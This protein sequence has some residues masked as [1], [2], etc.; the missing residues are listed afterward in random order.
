MI[1]LLTAI[2]WVSVVILAGWICLLV[3]NEPFVVDLLG[4]TGSRFVNMVMFGMLA[5]SSGLLVMYYRRTSPYID[6]DRV[7]TGAETVY[8]VVLF[9]A[10]FVGLYSA[11]IWFFSL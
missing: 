2:F 11:L 10:L 9:V 4:D 3:W 1:R 7:W 8:A 6:P 5:I